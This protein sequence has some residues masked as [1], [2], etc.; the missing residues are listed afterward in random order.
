MGGVYPYKDGYLT[1]FFEKIKSD[2]LTHYFGYFALIDKEK[3]QILWET[4]EP[5]WKSSDHW[6]K[7]K[8]AFLG[9][10]MINEKTISYWYRQSKRIFGI[11]HSG[12]FFDPKKILKTHLYI[13]RYEKNPIITPRKENS[14]ESFNT[15]NPA[16]FYYIKKFIFFI[17]LK[18]MIISRISVMLFLLMVIR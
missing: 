8:I 6:P 1:L 9:S 14:W 4:T 17:G 13:K 18:V 11:V 16:A 5:I 3:L 2:G 12:F 10:A 7:E 15:F